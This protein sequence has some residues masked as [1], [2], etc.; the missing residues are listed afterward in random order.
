M[1]PVTCEEARLDRYTQ[2][3]FSF[4]ILLEFG[5]IFLSVKYSKFVFVSYLPFLPGRLHRRYYN[6]K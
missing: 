5:I 1:S 4:K 6:E 3:T 2:P